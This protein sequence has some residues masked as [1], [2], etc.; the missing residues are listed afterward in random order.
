MSVLMIRL[1]LS[2]TGLYATLTWKRPMTWTEIS[3]IGPWIK[4]VLVSRDFGFEYVILQPHTCYWWM[5][6]QWVWTVGNEGSI[7]ETRYLCFCLMLS[8][9]MEVPSHLVA[10]AESAGCISGCKIWET[11]PS[12]LLLQFV[13]NSLFFLPNTATN[14]MNLMCILLMF[15][16]C[17]GLKINLPKSKIYAVRENQFVHKSAELLGCQVAS[18]PATYLGL[19]L[20]GIVK[21]NLY[22]TRWLSESSFPLQGVKDS[23]YLKEVSL[24]LSRASYQTCRCTTCP[25]FV[26]PSLFFNAL[27]RWEETFYGQ[28][29]M[30]K[31]SIIWYTGKR[32]VIPGATRFGD[33]SL[34]V[35]Q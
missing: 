34:E 33:M 6:L 3:L 24:L 9:K 13:D 20:G 5:V 27:I 2:L 23:I 4:W 8:W 22:G 35:G 7:R 11:S 26:P 32:L 30:M 10:K 29:W 19:P 18:L 28:P 14:I 15:E 12:V 21:R 16:A 31:R 17:F 25:S 1:G